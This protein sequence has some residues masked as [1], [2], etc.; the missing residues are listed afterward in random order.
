VT[1]DILAETTD[2][3]LNEAIVQNRA[4]LQE[5][6]PDLDLSIGG[7]VDSLLV[8]ANAA[9]AANNN[10]LV[11]QAYLF[12]QL[13]AIADGTVEVDDS[14]VDNLM[15]AYFLTR[16]VATP[17]TGQ[18]SFIVRDNVAYTFQSGYRL[19]TATQSYKL[20]LTYRVYPVGQTGVDFTVPTNVRLEQVYDE[21]TGYGY[22]FNVS[23]QSLQSVPDAILVSGDRLAVDQSFDGLGYVQAVTNFSGG[24]AA[25]TNSQ[26]VSRALSGLVANTVAGQDNIRAIVTE[27]VQRSDS[28][29]IGA[30]SPLMTR[31]RNNVFNLPTGGKIDVYVKAGAVAQSS[32]VD[33]TAVVVS[34]VSRTV[35][36]TLTREQSAGVYRTS[37]LPLFTTAPPVI[38]SGDLTVNSTTHLAWSDP[39]G[40]N[41]DAT[42]EI[43][44]AFSARQQIQLDITDDRQDGLGYVVPMTAPGDD[45]SG[46]YQ[47]NCQYQPQVLEQD[48]ALTSYSVRPPG[49][50]VLVKA[51]VPCLTTVGVI[52]SKPSG[53]T[54]PSADSIAAALSAMINQL[55]ITTPSLDLYTL[56]ALVREID[57]T[58]TV[59]SASL[60]G[61][62]YGQAGNNLSVSSV[63]GVLSL[64]TNLTDKVSPA[65]TYFATTSDSVTVTLV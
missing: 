58:L 60:T 13:K 8:N 45:L 28:S 41:P 21:E 44:L 11:N 6:F 36:I 46:F 10:L 57:N 9:I 26:F 51:A 15:D 43:D 53:Y 54:G 61:T 14:A 42:A 55:P 5:Q 40:F 27:T 31:D 52:A 56:A 17:A 65:N 39:S 25:E 48:V 62:I 50:D 38:I 12:Q 63:A 34:E 35:R 16:H 1:I 47:V 19:R 30:G 23:V 64:P 32:L 24:V 49:V 29:A 22:R 4:V 7:P 2:A 37:V 33:I 20:P 18:V 3:Q 59:T